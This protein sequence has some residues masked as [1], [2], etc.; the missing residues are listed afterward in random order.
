[1]SDRLHVQ[2]PGCGKKG[3]V[4]RSFAGRTILCKACSRSFAAPQSDPTASLIAAEQSARALSDLDALTLV[5]KPD[6]GPAIASKLNDLLSKEK[7]PAIISALDRIDRN[8]R[9]SPALDRFLESLAR[10][11]EEAAQHPLRESLG[12]YLGAIE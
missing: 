8:W 3:M 12:F 2:C 9:E 6:P 5:A 10:S 7:K 1:M 4:P 11:I